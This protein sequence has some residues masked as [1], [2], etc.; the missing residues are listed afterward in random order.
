MRS[1]RADQ[2]PR[3]RAKLGCSFAVLVGFLGAIEIV[4]RV[5]GYDPFG[6]MFSD[7]PEASRE[8]LELGLMRV[9][10]GED[11]LVYDLN[12]GARG[13]AWQ[14]DIQVN[15]HGFR[16]RDFRPKEPGTL[17][18][19]ALGDSATFGVKLPR[20]VLWP[21]EI[22]RALRKEGRKVEVFNLGIVGYDVLEEVALLEKH[23]EGLSPDKV[24][25]AYHP[26]D[27]GHVSATRTYIHR[28]QSYG[29]AWYRIRLLQYLR[30]RLDMSELNREFHMVNTDSYFLERNAGYIADLGDDPTTRRLVSELQARTADREDVKKLKH[31]YLEWYMNLDRLGKLRYSLER[32][33]ELAEARDFDVALFV[34]PWL[35][36]QGLEGAYDQLY[37]IVKY[38]TERSGFTYIPMAD[39]TRALGHGKLLIEKRDFGHPNSTGHRVMAER[40]ANALQW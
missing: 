36:D 39:A 2:R 5:A 16:D 21:A 18:I 11:I 12:P 22:E 14:A 32:L 4:L 3:L 10:D 7:A 30:S 27:I 28:L 13:Y 25:V 40:L 35:G 33:K 29:S 17:R 1:T 37:E 20:E 34:V 23:V 26:N 31:R 15:A 6:R 8:G 38:E 24:V 19:L 9:V